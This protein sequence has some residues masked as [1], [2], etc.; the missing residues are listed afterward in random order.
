M[1]C[2]LC[3]NELTAKSGGYS[4]DGR[5]V[6]RTCVASETIAAGDR[7]VQAQRENLAKV[8]RITRA[9]KLVQSAGAVVTVIGALHVPPWPV[10]ISLGVG[11]AM[12]GGIARMVM[13][14]SL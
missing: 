7:E 8:N 10:V 13:R 12:A 11:I 3:T 1:Q 6:C 4:E 9:T 2:A 5:R 14:S